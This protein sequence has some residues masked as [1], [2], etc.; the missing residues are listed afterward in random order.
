VPGDDAAAVT[1]EVNDR[2][3]AG[4]AVHHLRSFGARRMASVCRHRGHAVMVVVT[5]ARLGHAR[6]EHGGER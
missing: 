2:S 4:G 3:R 5:V 6:G 1:V